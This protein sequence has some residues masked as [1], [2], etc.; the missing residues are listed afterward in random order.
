[1]CEDLVVGFKPTIKS[2][3]SVVRA[4]ASVVLQLE[5]SLVS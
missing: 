5:S 2:V 3:L 4:Q 1:M